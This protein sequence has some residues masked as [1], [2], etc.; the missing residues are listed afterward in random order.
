MGWPPSIFLALHPGNWKIIYQKDYSPSSVS[1]SLHP[2]F[3]THPCLLDPR[4]CDFLFKLLL[5][6]N[7]SSIK[8]ALFLYYTSVLISTKITTI[9]FPW[10]PQYTDQE[11]LQNWRTETAHGHNTQV[12]WPESRNVCIFP[13]DTSYVPDSVPDFPC[14]S[15]LNKYT[16]YH[17]NNKYLSTWP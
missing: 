5:I 16:H 4:S 3:L 14:G 8:A 7:P 10:I 15:V 1:F 12:T 9:F 2:F 13:R 11:V 17:H 6:C